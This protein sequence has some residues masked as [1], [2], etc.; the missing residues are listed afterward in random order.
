MTTIQQLQQAGIPVNV[1]KSNETLGM[2]TFDGDLTREQLAT[3]NDIIN[4][5]DY[6]EIRRRAYPSVADQLDTIYWDQINGTHKWTDL[7]TSI[8]NQYPK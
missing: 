7:I 5:P 1:E 6:A 8:K 4:P 2:F 3:V